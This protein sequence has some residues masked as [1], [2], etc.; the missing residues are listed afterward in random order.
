MSSNTRIVRNVLLAIAAVTTVAIVMGATRTHAQSGIQD[1]VI[2]DRVLSRV[3]IINLNDTIARVDTVTGSIHILNGDARSPSSRNQWRLYAPGVGN[4]SGY[5]E[6][7]Q[8][9]G[10]EAQGTMFLVDIVTGE[11]WIFNRRGPGRA[12]W[13]RV[14]VFNR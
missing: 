6:I 11:S 7:Q 9:R 2:G 5:L 12:S 4:T 14:D 13:D 8:P 10:V 1:R 3:Q